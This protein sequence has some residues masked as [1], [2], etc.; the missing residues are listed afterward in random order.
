MTHI[1]DGFEISTDKS[2]L[3]IPFIHQYL[4]QSYWSEGIPYETVKRS[5]EGSLCFG[6]YHSGKQIGF[7]RL[8]TDQATFAYL[9]DVFIDELYRGRGLSKWLIKV[10][11]EH[12]STQGLR[13][14]MLATRDAHGLYTQF[15]FSPITFP[16]R[17]MQIHKPDLY[18]KTDTN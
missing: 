7:A 10:V 13:R 8:I 12:P 15:G 16:E 14:F 3:D 11:M 2:F 17:W 18:K 1:Q 5:I 9:A 4:A 6:V